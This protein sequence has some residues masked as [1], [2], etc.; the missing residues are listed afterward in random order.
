MAS[1]GEDFRKY[2]T[3]DFYNRLQAMLG[4]SQRST[5]T[6][7]VTVSNTPDGSQIVVPSGRQAVSTIQGVIAGGAAPSVSDGTEILDP[8]AFAAYSVQAAYFIL[9]AGTATL[10]VQIDGTPISWLDS[11]AI[12]S[13]ATKIFIPNP[14]PDLTNVVGVGSQ[15]SIVLTGSSGTAAGLSFSLNTPF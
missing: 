13:V 6:G 15:L 10:S 5:G 9:A 14:A 7:R 4:R 2:W 11:L 8:C 12:S 3:A 1:P